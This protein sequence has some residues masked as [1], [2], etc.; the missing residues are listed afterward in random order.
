MKL[1][2]ITQKEYD[3]LRRKLNLASEKINRMK[4]YIDCMNPEH[5]GC[6]RCPNCQIFYEK[7]QTEFAIQDKNESEVK[8][9]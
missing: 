6:D 7:L 1:I 3:N 5:C 8:S 2:E 9:K 4:K